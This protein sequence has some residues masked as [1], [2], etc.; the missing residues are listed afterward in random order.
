[1]KTRKSVVEKYGEA[2]APVILSY[3]GKIAA[4]GKQTAALRA[5]LAL[6]SEP[7]N[8]RKQRHKDDTATF[9]GVDGLSFS[10]QAK[11]ISATTINLEAAVEAHIRKAGE[12]LGPKGEKRDPKAT[13]DKCID[14]IGRMLARLKLL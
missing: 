13:R 3:S 9:S 12:E 1:M 11:S 14:Q 6:H 8:K 10:E 5:K 4:R 2:A 7:E